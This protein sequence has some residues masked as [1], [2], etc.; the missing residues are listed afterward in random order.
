MAVIL[1]PGPFR[2]AERLRRF[3][4]R[5]EKYV[6]SSRL[7]SS[8][9]WKDKSRDNDRKR[10]FLH[11]YSDNLRLRYLIPLKS[12]EVSRVPR[13]NN[14]QS[15]LLY[16]MSTAILQNVEQYVSQIS[17]ESGL[18]VDYYHDITNL[19]TSSDIMK[20]SNGMHLRK[21]R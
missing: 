21:L 17:H 14:H 1:T 20:I 7:E 12:K 2:I 5:S 10:I 11:P 8:C 4:W 3:W 18:M 16:T 9:R 15:L 13:V 19:S 6:R